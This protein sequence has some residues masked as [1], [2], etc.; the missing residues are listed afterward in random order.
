[1]QLPY[2]ILQILAVLGALGP[3]L[4]STL[5]LCQKQYVLLHADYY[6]CIFHPHNY[7]EDGLLTPTKPYES[8]ARMEFCCL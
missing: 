7:L 2:D 3:L 8:G 4:L 5:G 6:L 1:M